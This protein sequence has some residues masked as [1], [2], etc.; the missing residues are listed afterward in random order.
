MK[1]GITIRFATTSIWSNG[2]N[3][4][5]IYLGM[6]LQRGG[7]DVY[8]IHSDE[9]ITLNTKL[10]TVDVLKQIPSNLKTIGFKDSFKESWDVVIKLSLTVED[11]AKNKWLEKNKNFKLVSYECSCKLIIDS[12][13]IIFEAHGANEKTRKINYAACDQ[14]WLIPQHESMNI[15]Y[16]Q[17]TNECE[18]ATVV[19]FVWDPIAIKQVAKEKGYKNYEKRSFENIA[20]MEPNT[21]MIKTCITPTMIV[22]KF[23]K[24]E[25]NNIK[26]L[27][28]AGAKRLKN[29]N[30]FLSFIK[31][32]KLFKDNLISAEERVYTHKMLNDYADLIVSWQWENALNYFYID[33][34]YLGFPIIHNAHLCKDIGYYY[35][36]CD[37]DDGV[38]NLKYAIN[39][40]NE[41]VDYM[42]NMRNIIKRYTKD[43][44]DMIKGYNSLLEDL[45]NNRFTKRKYNWKTNTINF[46]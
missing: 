15:P 17:F 13:R 26:H 22:D 4:N 33:V 38:D 44:E 21:N 31:K 8:L 7:H 42:K 25:K 18:N 46:I 12:E 40:H 37:V 9:T 41:N 2:I 43:N 16:F 20:I 3:Q 14:V 27:Y 39:T 29:N 1:I 34:A 35:K 36:G 24:N 5:A 6:A 19:P 32:T 11:F 30:A 28:I 45:V 10:T 23:Y